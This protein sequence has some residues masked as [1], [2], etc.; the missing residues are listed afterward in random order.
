[1]FDLDGTI[2]DTET[3][4]FQS[5]RGVWQAHGAEYT[6]AHFEHVIGTTQGP[7]WIEELQRTIGTAV[8]TRTASAMRR[9]TKRRLLNA[10][11]ARDGIRALIEQAASAGVPMAIASN[12]PL[13]WVEAR[14]AHLD[15]RHH[16]AALI[17]IDVAS[18]PKPHPEPYLEAC[19][20]LGATPRLSIAFEDSAT[21]V[22]SAR[23]AGLYTIACAGPLTL[24]HD[25][26]RAHRTIHS[27]S[28]ITLHD[29]G[30]AVRG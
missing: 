17:T 16:I 15:L 8:D 20:A 11:V 27:H 30:L 24:G 23:A 26:S 1:M 7:D 19:I 3:V 5:I 28:E 6:V 13:D 2:V 21:G 14:L 9:E 22:A 18:L 4:E 29:L 12:S 25:L 10:A